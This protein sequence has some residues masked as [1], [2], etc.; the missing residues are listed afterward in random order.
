MDTRSAV[1]QFILFLTAVMLFH[2]VVQGAAARD[3]GAVL[4]R[5]SPH[6]FLSLLSRP[7]CRLRRRRSRSDTAAAASD[8]AVSAGPAVR[9]RIEE[10]EKR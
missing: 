8:T 1:N 3:D 2:V 7:R 9:G 4:A 6:G 10:G 5:V